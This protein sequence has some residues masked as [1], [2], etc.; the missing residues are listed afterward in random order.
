MKVKLIGNT[1]MWCSTFSLCPSNFHLAVSVSCAPMAGVCGVSLDVAACTF[2]LDRLRVQHIR[3]LHVL[4]CSQGN[5]DLCYTSCIYLSVRCI[6]E[7]PYPKVARSNKE[8][9]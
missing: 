7:R 3:R 2:T 9:T 4:L 5:I 6:L 1:N 8:I